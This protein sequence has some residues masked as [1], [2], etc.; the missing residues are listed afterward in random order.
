MDQNAL[1]K[2]CCLLPIPQDAYAIGYI[3]NTVDEAL[4]ITQEAGTWKVFFLERGSPREEQGFEDFETA[5][6]YFLR[7][8]LEFVA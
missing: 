8:L 3:G 2:I 5:G 6:L 7:R 1:A 4:C